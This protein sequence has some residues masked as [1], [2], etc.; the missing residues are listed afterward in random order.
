[1]VRWRGRQDGP[2]TVPELEQRLAD[3][4][5]GMLHEVHTQAGWLPL[6]EFFEARAVRDQV[7]Q[8][9]TER[10]R[11]VEEQK[12]LQAQEDMAAQ[13]QAEAEQT[14]CQ[15]DHELRLRELEVEKI[16]AQ[17]VQQSSTS[18][19][20]WA[21]VM[22]VVLV[23]A[24][25]LY[26]ASEW[27]GPSSESMAEHVQTEA[28]AKY[29]AERNPARIVSVSLVKESS[30]KYSGIAKFSDGDMLSVTVSRDG[31]S[32]YWKIGN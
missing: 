15:Q 22:V 8:K 29:A 13:R 11:A 30:R 28:N 9:E 21:G 4:R 27:T 23:I 19:G 6:R 24:A 16:R 32:T 5:L 18:T 26:S 10:L 12:R 3:N 31:E 17:T 2:F 20:A 25:V 14:R 1:M 7:R